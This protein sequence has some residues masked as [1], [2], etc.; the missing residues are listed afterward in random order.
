MVNSKVESEVWGVIEWTE[1]CNVQFIHGFDSEVGTLRDVL[2]HIG[3]NIRHI[4]YWVKL[5]CVRGS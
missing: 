2:N 3:R 1:V 5:T 4:W